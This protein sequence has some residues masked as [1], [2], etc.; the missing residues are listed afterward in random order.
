MA[1]S[2]PLCYPILCAFPYSTPSFLSCSIST[3]VVMFLFPADSQSTASLRHALCAPFF[4]SVLLSYIVRMVNAIVAGECVIVALV[5]CPLISFAL[6]TT[7]LCSCLDVRKVNCIHFIQEDNQ[8]L[9]S[10]LL[11]TDLTARVHQ[12]V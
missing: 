12:C 6:R 10:S 3:P 11:L 7:Q 4:H 9:Q 1:S 2:I 5:Q 8:S